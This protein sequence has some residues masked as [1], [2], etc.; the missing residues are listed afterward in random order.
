MEARRSLAWQKAK[1][2]TLDQRRDF[3]G[4]LRALVREARTRAVV[5]RNR[6]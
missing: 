3:P 4:L 2:S 6:Q 5:G 1:S